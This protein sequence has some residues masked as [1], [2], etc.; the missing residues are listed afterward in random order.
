M[1]KNSDSGFRF[2][3]C[4]TKNSNPVRLEIDRRIN[5]DP[6]RRK[7]RMRR[8]TNNCLR[9]D[10][11]IKRGGEWRRPNCANTTEC[12]VLVQQLIIAIDV[13]DGGAFSSFTFNGVNHRHIHQNHHH[14]REN[15][16]AVGSTRL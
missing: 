3:D 5:I 10:L 6:V 15:E 4:H 7:P 12:D 11:L 2:Q 1:S 13:G 9:T 16:R 14:E 8:E